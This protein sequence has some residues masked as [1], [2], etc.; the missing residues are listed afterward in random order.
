MNFDDM[1]S[2]WDKEPSGDV[3][4]PQ[5]TTLLGKAKHPVDQ[6]KRNM[7]AELWTQTAAIVIMAFYPMMFHLDASLN[8]Y[9][10]LVYAL[11]VVISGYYIIGFYRFYKQMHNYASDTRDSLLEL[12]YELRLSMERYKSFGFLLLPFANIMIGLKFYS[13][14]LQ[15]GI[16]MD[17]FP[18][19]TLYAMLLIVIAEVLLMM[20]ALHTWVNR[21]YGKYARQIKSVSD[22]LKEEI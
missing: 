18:D 12:Y 11:F 8:N 2:R 6:L 3:K 13:N 9:Y 22:E 15:K 7:R 21:F 14:Q 10:Y 4:I 20:W 1:K 16:P 5:Q 17:S 19:K